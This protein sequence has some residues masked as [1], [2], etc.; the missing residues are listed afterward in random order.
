MKD[1]P[2][3]ASA[4]PSGHCGGECNNAKTNIDTGPG[5]EHNAWLA[6]RHKEQ[7]PIRSTVLSITRL[8]PLGPQPHLFSLKPWPAPFPSPSPRPAVIRPS[9]RPQSENKAAWGLAS[10]R[11]ANMLSQEVLTRAGDLRLL[12]IMRHP[13]R[14]QLLPSLKTDSGRLAI[15]ML[16]ALPSEILRLAGGCIGQG[17]AAAPPPHPLHRL[18]GTDGGREGGE[19]VNL[20]TRSLDELPYFSM[21]RRFTSTKRTIDNKRSSVPPQFPSLFQDPHKSAVGQLINPKNSVWGTTYT[22]LY[23]VLPR[24]P[25]LSRCSSSRH[26]PLIIRFR[27]RAQ[28]LRLTGALNNKKATHFLYENS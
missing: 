25:A 10:I 28:K 27:G 23:P 13:D 15:N 1:T 21:P 20:A 9:H 22:L 5:E 8:I 12:L 26:P 16:S 3:P 2:R 17:A 14:P 11:S 18:R 7:A 4:P 6:H 24:R 19:R